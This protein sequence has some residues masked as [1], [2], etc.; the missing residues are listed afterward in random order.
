MCLKLS[1]IQKSLSETEV[2][3]EVGPKA[4]ME[5]PVLGQLFDELAQMCQH[6]FLAGRVSVTNVRL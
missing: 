3:A 1:R 2:T 5:T 4:Y 6:C